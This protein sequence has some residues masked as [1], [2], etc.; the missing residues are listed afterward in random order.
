MV[1]G[2]RP[3]FS[4]KERSGREKDLK[5]SREISSLPWKDEG[6]IADGRCA[7]EGIGRIA[8]CF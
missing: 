7:G 4:G 2:I 1:C 3:L 6:E 8:R 5:K